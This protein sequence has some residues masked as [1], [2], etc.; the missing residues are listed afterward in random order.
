L[1]YARRLD[2]IVEHRE[3][4]DRRIRRTKSTGYVI[5]EELCLIIPLS[6]IMGC[7]NVFFVFLFVDSIICNPNIYSSSVEGPKNK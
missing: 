7:W 3:R 2:S 6:T 4:L 1:G 5:R